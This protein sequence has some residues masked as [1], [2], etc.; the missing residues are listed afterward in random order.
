MKAGPYWGE[1]FGLKPQWF[2]SEI[3]VS[4]LQAGGV[5]DK[6]LHPSM[7]PQTLFTLLEES[8][9]PDCVRDYADMKLVFA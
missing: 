2:C 9:T 4:A 7:H 6:S 8:T 5:L 1:R 3:C